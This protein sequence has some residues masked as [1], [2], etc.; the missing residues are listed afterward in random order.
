MACIYAKMTAGAF[1]RIE[2]SAY[3]TH[4]DCI[5]ANGD[6]HV[7]RAM[8]HYRDGKPDYAEGSFTK[9]LRNYVRA[10]RAGAV[11]APD[12]VIEMLAAWRLKAEVKRLQALH[13]RNCIIRVA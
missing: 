8:Q 1:W 6:R 5:A 4:S 13:Q 2:M 10:A 3:A 12:E 7:S 9:A 11:S